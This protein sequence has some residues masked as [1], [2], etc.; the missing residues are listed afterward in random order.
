MVGRSERVT[1]P[2]VDYTGKPMMEG[3]GSLML[4]SH[5]DCRGPGHNDVIRAYGRDWLCHHMYDAQANGVP[6]LQIRPL[7]WGRDGWPVAGE[8]I[9]DSMPSQ[10]VVSA[11]G[12]RGQWMHSVDYRVPNPL[13]FL[14]NGK[15]NGEE[16]E[17][18]WDF[19]R[20]LLTL[21]WPRA[22][23]PGGAWVDQCVMG[24]TG[25]YYVGRNQGGNVIRGLR[26]KQ[27]IPKAAGSGEARD[28]SRLDSMVGVGIQLENTPSGPS[29]VRVLPDSPAFYAGVEAGEI[30]TAVNGV[31]TAGI[32]VKDIVAMI[33]GPEGS[34][35]ELALHKEERGERT[36]T[37]FRGRFAVTCFESRMVDGGIGIVDIDA[38][39]SHTLDLLRKAITEFANKK[40]KGL[41]ID[42]RGNK[43]GKYQVIV[44]CA[45]LFLVKWRTL[46]LTKDSNGK[47]GAVR[48]KNPQVTDLPLVVVIDGN[49]GGGE[50]FAAAMKRNNRGKIVGQ[51]SSG[52]AA[53]KSK[54]EKADGSYEVKVMAEVLM[55]RRQP[56]TGV[57]VKPD[58]VLGDDVTPDV[59]L[60]KAIELL[61]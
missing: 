47:V 46:W 49:T 9:G 20:D 7:L 19:G 48:S 52:L 28:A 50:L 4:Q 12:L 34:R 2:Y 18:T 42:L 39:N 22:G 60:E 33:V 38:F 40:A 29:I 17:I 1:G 13:M 43:G 54:V 15:V 51:Q 6:T 55:R 56:V 45:A 21:R 3:G 24:P 23:A 5:D 10:T 8:P 53:I 59:V 14:A 57:G 41:V 31:K 37:V 61:R 35:V 44:D 58:V 36:V 30:I 32:P 27:D 25:D 16:G 11:D 26:V